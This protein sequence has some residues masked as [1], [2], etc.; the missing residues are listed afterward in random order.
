MKSREIPEPR[1]SHLRLVDVRG[2]SRSVHPS[3]RPLKIFDQDLQDDP[4]VSAADR[5]VLL[6][7]IEAQLIASLLNIARAH[8]PSPKACDQAIELLVGPRP[9]RG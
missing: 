6:T 8:L 9:N 1:N 5:C 2:R 4:E 3:S 7:K